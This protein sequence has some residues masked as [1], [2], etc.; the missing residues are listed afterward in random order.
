MSQ[1]LFQNVTKTYVRKPGQ[2]WLKT[3]LTDLARGDRKPFEALRNVSFS[4]KEGKSVALVGRNGAGKSTILNLIAGLLIPNAGSV[5]TEGRIAALLDLGAGFHGDLTGRENLT[6]NAAL[7]GLS[8]S[9]VRDRTDSIIEFSGLG[10]FIDQPTR[11]YSSGM[12]MRLAFAVATSV[13]P[14]ILL[15]DEILAVGDASFQARCYER[16]QQLKAKGKIFVCVSHSLAIDQLCETAIWIEQGVV[17][18]TGPT[19]DVIAAYTESLSQNVEIRRVPTETPSRPAR[20]RSSR[21]E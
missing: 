21:R 11:T 9:E 16:I 2:Q 10:D 4:I 7:M 1:I 5:Q 3:H 12:S 15:I 18:K 8:R 20:R 17:Y 14:D 19:P 13:D 6:I